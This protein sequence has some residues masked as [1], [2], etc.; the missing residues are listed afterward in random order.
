MRLP[1]APFRDSQGGIEIAAFGIDSS[2]AKAVPFGAL[3]GSA[4]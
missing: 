2:G 4:A 1:A 3:F